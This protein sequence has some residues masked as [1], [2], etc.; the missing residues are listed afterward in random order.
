MKIEQHENLNADVLI[1]VKFRA[2]STAYNTKSVVILGVIEDG[3]EIS[4]EKRKGSYSIKEYKI[5]VECF[6]S[7]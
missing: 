2:R 7:F 1:T 4:D 5:L 3:N 6:T